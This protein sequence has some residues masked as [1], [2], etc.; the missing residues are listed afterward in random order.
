MSKFIAVQGCVLKCG[1]PTAQ[2]TI[3][4]NPSVKVKADGKGCYSGVINITVI[5]A[6]AGTVSQ[7]KDGVGTI[8]GS[9][10]KVKIDGQGAVLMGDSTKDPIICP[11]TDSA[12]GASATIPVPVT[13]L[14]AGQTKVMGS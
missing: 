9:A 10:I 2:A 8:T 7:T 6:T 3:T 4:T 1:N 12:S 5:G 11:A 13:I 14:D